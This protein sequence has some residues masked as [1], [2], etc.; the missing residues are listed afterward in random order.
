MAD[1]LPVELQTNIHD[2]VHDMIRME[3]Q[4]MAREKLHQFLSEADPQV[5]TS[6]LFNYREVVMVENTPMLLWSPQYELLT[7]HTS[8]HINHV[9]K[10]A[11]LQTE[12]EQQQIL[13]L[14]FPPPPLV[15]DHSPNHEEIYAI[16]VRYRDM[17]FLVYRHHDAV[18]IHTPLPK[19]H[20]T[21]IE[22]LWRAAIATLVVLFKRVFSSTHPNQFRLI[23]SG[24]AQE[25]RLID[26]VREM[27]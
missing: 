7:E 2:K 17:V 5:F 24:A 22:Q 3:K 18:R 1:V 25:E 8:V 12:I 26:V 23:H 6:P 13:L 9:L 20:V 14:E 11:Q 10:D 15:L 21:A 19:S 16:N 4:A 27:M